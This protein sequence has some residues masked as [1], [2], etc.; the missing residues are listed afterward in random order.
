MIDRKSPV[1][2]LSLDEPSRARRIMNFAGRSAKNTFKAIKWLGR[3]APW[4][5]AGS[6]AAVLGYSLTTGPVGIALTAP[7]WG[8]GIYRGVRE[9]IAR[10]RNG[11]KRIGGPVWANKLGDKMNQW[12]GQ[13]EQEEGVQNEQQSEDS[14]PTVSAKTEKNESKKEPEN[15]PK[16]P[17]QETVEAEP[18][19]GN[20]KEE[21]RKLGDKQMELLKKIENLTLLAE[22][23]YLREDLGKDLSA[24]TKL[25]NQASRKTKQG[26]GLW[27][28]R[29][30]AIE[31]RLAELNQ[32][33]E[34]VGKMQS[35]ENEVEKETEKKK[36]KK[37]EKKEPDEKP[38]PP[39]K[40]KASRRL[41]VDEIEQQKKLEEL[42]AKKKIKQTKKQ[43]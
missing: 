27:K 24:I 41:N 18:E 42:L 22:N 13:E 7:I 16:E 21:L 31:K 6:S 2:P 4:V 8:Y 28:E 1:V 5:T 36:R 40:P 39:Q 34:E 23:E 20:W 10:V 3:R 35:E 15:S 30:T 26:L 25:V 14:K 11:E 38:K 12:F 17:E 19:N 37:T 9:I 32:R 43:A 33:Y 29:K